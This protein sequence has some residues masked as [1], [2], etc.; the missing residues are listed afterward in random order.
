MNDAYRNLDLTGRVITITG[1]ASGLG[2]ATAELVV[3][4]GAAVM[5]ADIDAD[6]V[7]AR[8]AE[9][10]ARGGRAAAIRTDVSREDD[11][12]AM[13]DCA[14]ERFGG[15]HGAF[16]NAGIDTGHTGITDTPLANWQRSLDVNLTGIM[17]CMKYQ[18]GHMLAHGGGS[19]VNTSSSAGAVGFANAIA[20]VASKHGV[21]GLTRAAAM[22][23]AA[24]GIRINALL[25]G[26]VE[27]PMLEGAFNDPPL[28]AYIER[29]HP[30]GRM[31]KPFEIAETVAWLLSDASSFTTGAALHIDGGF[32]TC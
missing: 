3:A 8:A 23:V 10:R 4:R 5:L 2:W 9:L 32:T 15:L 6:G 29:S 18:V 17:L 30:I 28:R 7:E 27:T 11:V 26:S 19:I 24:K 12:K 14:I 13:V 1:G 31:G 21:V 25:P 22:D 20:Y 16:N